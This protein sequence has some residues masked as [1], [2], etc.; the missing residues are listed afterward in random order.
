MNKAQVIVL[1]KLRHNAR[2]V[3]KQWHMYPPLEA[4]LHTLEISHETTN[5]NMECAITQAGVLCFCEPTIEDYTDQ[6]GGTLVL[7]R[8]VRWQ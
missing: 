6:G 4:K 3:N 7:H 8:Q 1:S 2:C 5:V